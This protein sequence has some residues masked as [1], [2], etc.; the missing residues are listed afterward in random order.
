MKKLI[1]LIV[2]AATFA[3]CSVSNASIT[4]AW[5]HDNGDG[6]VVC[7]SWLYSGSSLTMSGTQYASPGHMLGWVETDSIA[8][9]TLFLGSS[10]NN[11]TSGAWI[12]YQVNVAMSQTFTFSGTP[13]VSNPDST[14]F[15]ASVVA[16]TLQVS[17]PYAGD[18][19]GTIYYSG[20]TPLAI[21][22]ELDFNYAIHFSSSLDYAFTQE[23][24]PMLAPVP[25]PG[26]IGLLAIGGL[27]LAV[28]LRRN[29][30]QGA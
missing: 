19:E 3:C 22:Q 13:G 9:P 11:D 28:R 7:S 14:W 12:G 30:R 25:E 10:V 24:I 2:V 18:Y 27:G 20:G 17:G 6:S 4:N 15:L 23:M 5:W 1:A 26:T 16:P 8:D 29:R 21:G